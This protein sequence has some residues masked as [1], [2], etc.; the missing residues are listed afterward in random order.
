MINGQST[1]IHLMLEIVVP[2]G[3]DPTV[4]LEAACEVLRNKGMR[5]EGGSW[6][7]AVFDHG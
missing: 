3:V 1:R 6:H 2:P 4:A 7:E 5:V